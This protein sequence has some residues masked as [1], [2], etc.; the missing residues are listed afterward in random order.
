MPVAELRIW[1][2]LV[3]FALQIVR[4]RRQQLGKLLF[5]IFANV[6]SFSLSR[7]KHEPMD[8]SG[9][10]VTVTYVCW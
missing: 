1:N 2:V 9:P 8:P 7:Q 10:S 5:V 3:M 4:V 6:M